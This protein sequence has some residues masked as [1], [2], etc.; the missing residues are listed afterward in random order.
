MKRFVEGEDRSAGIEF[1][2]D[3]GFT[4]GASVRYADDDFSFGK[5]G[6]LKLDEPVYLLTLGARLQD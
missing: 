3:N 2:L 4:F 5:A 6:D 1:V